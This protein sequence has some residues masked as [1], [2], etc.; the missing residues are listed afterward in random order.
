M[1]QA[2]LL[3]AVAA[4]ANV[5]AEAGESLR[6][7]V[8]I[9]GSAGV[10]N[11][12]LVGASGL[13]R[14]AVAEITVG[15]DTRGRGLN[16][17]EVEVVLRRAKTVAIVAAGWNGYRDYRSFHAYICQPNRHFDPATERFGFYADQEVKAEFP[18]ILDSERA[19]S[20]NDKTSDRLRS[21][22]RNLL[23]DIVDKVVAVDAR[24]TVSEHDVY[25]LSGPDDI[26]H[27]LRLGA[28]IRHITSGPGTGFVQKQRYV[29]EHALRQNPKTTR[30]LLLLDR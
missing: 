25:A 21:E 13:S 10:S 16:A 27:T 17:A 15:Y 19:L 5:C 7:L 18:K 29:S 14:S 9:A 26:E 20:F 2:E 28:P 4:A 8:A 11:A 3:K 22:G 12:E 24:D 6:L 30:D 1:S 23:A